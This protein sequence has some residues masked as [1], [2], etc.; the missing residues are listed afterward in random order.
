[1]QM[2]GCDFFVFC[3]LL[4]KNSAPRNRKNSAPRNLKK[5]SPHDD[6]F[7]IHMGSTLQATCARRWQVIEETGPPLLEGEPKPTDLWI[8]WLIHM[9][10]T[11]PSLP[12]CRTVRH[13]DAL[14]LRFRQAAADRHAGRCMHESPLLMP[15]ANFYQLLQLGDVRGTGL[16]KC[17][18]AWGKCFRR[19]PAET[20]PPPFHSP[21]GG[22]T[23]QHCKAQVLG[24]L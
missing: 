12:G 14:M 10:S 18:A 15:G 4:K 5:L 24:T 7:C 23:A 16:G 6:P 20:S 17:L 13:L 11:A 9:G 1:M 22:R 3:F 19:A 21:R 8:N 2:M